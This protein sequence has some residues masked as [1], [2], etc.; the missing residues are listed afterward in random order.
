MY[1]DQLWCCVGIVLWVCCSE[2]VIGLLWC[3]IMC[4]KSMLMRVSCVIWFDIVVIWNG[5]LCVWVSSM[6]FVMSVNGEFV[7]FVMV[8]V[9]VLVFWDILSVWIVFVVFLLWE[10]VIVILF[11]V[12]SVVVVIVRC[13]LVECEM[14]YLMCVSLSCRFCVVSDDVVW[15]NRLMCWVVMIVWVIWLSVGVLRVS[16]VFLIVLIFCVVSFVVIVDGLLFGLIVV[17]FRLNWVCCVCFSVMVLV[18]V[19]CSFWQ[20]LQLS[21]CVQWVIVDSEV[22]YSWVRLLIV[23]LMMSVGF[24]RIVFVMCV[25]VVFIFGSECCINVRMLLFMDGFC[26]SWFWGFFV[27]WGSDLEVFC[28]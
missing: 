26:F 6:M 11:E 2:M 23:R 12:C 24:L 16:V 8:I 15:L 22:W 4:M 5:D 7:V 27:I 20:L 17:V 10:N 1:C 21:D 9:S 25:L 14:E 28:V 18:M 13:G 3:C 19:M